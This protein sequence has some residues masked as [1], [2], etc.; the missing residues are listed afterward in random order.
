MQEDPVH[1]A[2]GGNEV[3]T[4]T[5]EKKYGPVTVNA[6]VSAP[7]IEEAVDKFGPDARVVFPIDG[8]TFFEKLDP[9]EIPVPDYP[10]SRLLEAVTS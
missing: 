4:V 8:D 3:I 5:V 9:A 10:E 1:T 6:K 2:R 7:S